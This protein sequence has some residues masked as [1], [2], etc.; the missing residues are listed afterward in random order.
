MNVANSFFALHDGGMSIEE[1]TN[2]VALENVTAQVD[3]VV[4]EQSRRL[5]YALHTVLVPDQVPETALTLD[6]LIHVIGEA[7]VLFSRPHREVVESLAIFGYY[8]L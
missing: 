5:E 7:G 3:P 1:A 2:V 4:A 8:D 6:E